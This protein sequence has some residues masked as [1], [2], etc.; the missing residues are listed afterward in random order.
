MDLTAVMTDETSFNGAEILK[1]WDE[2][3]L[4]FEECKN[5]SLAHMPMLEKLRKL[6]NGIQEITELFFKEAGRFDCIRAA[7]DE[8]LNGHGGIIPMLEYLS[9]VEL[10]N[11]D[12][13]KDSDIEVEVQAINLVVTV[14]KSLQNR[15]PLE[16]L[17][18]RI[19]LR[20]IVDS[21]I[22]ELLN[23]F[24]INPIP[25]EILAEADVATHFNLYSDL[26]QRILSKS[27]SLRPEIRAAAE[28]NSERSTGGFQY[29]NSLDYKT[30]QL[31]ILEILPG[32]R[33]DRII[34]R[35]VKCDLRDGI[36]EALSYVWGKDMSQTSIQVDGQD[37]H[38]TKNLYEIL[39][40]IR[41]SDRIRAI[42]IDAVCINQ[43]DAQEKTH[44]VR[45][46]GDIYSKAENTIIWLGDDNDANE[47][48][49][50]MASWC[51]PFPDG[52]KGLT[53]NEYDLI[54]ILRE[55]K[56]YSFEEGEWS[57]RQ[58]ILYAMLRRCFARIV[59]R[60]WWERVWTLQE[61]ALPPKAPLFFFQ[62]HNFSFDELVDAQNL[63]HKLDPLVEKQLGN[64]CNVVGNEVEKIIL[65]LGKVPGESL[66]RSRLLLIYRH[67]LERLEKTRKPLFKTLPSLLLHTCICQ[68]T[69]P[70]DKIFAL[71]SLLSKPLG[72]LIQI[73]YSEECE[74]TFKRATARSINGYGLGLTSSFNFL[75]ESSLREGKTPTGPSWVLD[76]TYSD[77]QF[78]R[79]N[80]PRDWIDGVT[81]NTFMYDHGPPKVRKAPFGRIYATP[82]SLFCAGCRIDEVCHIGKVA[83]PHDFP[84]P[85]DISELFSKEGY[86]LNIFKLPY[87]IYMA[88][89]KLLGQVDFQNPIDII[90]ADD[91]ETLDKLKFYMELL[92]PKFERPLLKGT[93]MADLG[94]LNYELA[95]QL[96]FIT[97][98]GLVGLSTAPIEPGDSLC[99]IDTARVYI[100][101]RDVKDE[102]GSPR[103]R[104][105]VSRAA[106]SYGFDMVKLINSK[107]RCAFQIV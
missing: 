14:G 11:L 53:I 94:F 83:N 49:F 58:W 31:R 65:A 30:D 3:R 104:R 34:C 81:P 99:Y 86:P 57:K 92:S 107:E 12:G 95:D 19:I 103:T 21:A 29:S 50:D 22:F 97:K 9:A 85:S 70:K 54:A 44:Q 75:F 101:L 32:V 16:P 105:I 41:Y 7:L 33:D 96:C 1:P 74:E 80:S 69:E 64:M 23:T 10:I 82:K 79:S 72:K 8:I 89:G 42:W 13:E 43:S 40:N 37:F 4:N 17:E 78:S 106:I 61:A 84:L 5:Q 91:E 46:M 15:G 68:A 76:F 77:A 88:R 73:D 98:E 62:G 35:L 63:I 93:T 102:N 39:R 56:K 100:I 51:P 38:V 47:C 67:G 24:R 20:E 2:L 36:P 48:A 28:P 87:A 26:C 60:D 90:Q 71:A 6:A 59:F 25:N 45:M 55:A 66:A 18:Y 52:A 27:I